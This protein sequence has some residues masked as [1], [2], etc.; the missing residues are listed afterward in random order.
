MGFEQLAGFMPFMAA[1][2]IKLVVLIGAGDANEKSM[3]QKKLK[4]V[5]R[6]IQKPGDGASF[7]VPVSKGVDG[8]RRARR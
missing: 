5:F 7:K 3:S 2:Y 4:N 8:R 1:N 6:P